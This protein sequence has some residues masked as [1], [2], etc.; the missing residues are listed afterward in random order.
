MPH[1]VAEGHLALQ[2][3]YE[4]SVGLPGALEM[5]DTFD[6]TGK[7]YT[8]GTYAG[9]GTFADGFE[10]KPGKRIP[11]AGLYA[12]AGVGLARAEWRFFDAEAKGPNA[13]A[14]VGA[15]AASLSARAFARAEVAS[16]SATAGPVKA[17]VG[18]AVD[19]GVGVVCNVSAGLP[20]LLGMIDAFDQPGNVFAVGPYAS[21]GAFAE[22]FEN[23]PGKRLPKA[24]ANPEA[25]VGH[26]QA[27]RSVF[28]AE[29]KG[30]NASAGVNASAADLG[31]RAFAKAELASASATA[32]PVKATAGLA[33]NTGVSVGPT[34]L[35][36]KVLGTGFSIGP[37]P[38]ISLFG[39]GIEFNQQ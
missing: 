17:T 1:P 37:K 35:E 5:I 19:T 18:L 24:G 6:R 16:A 34:G 12:S 21:A 11:K 8:A 10:D 23:K 36:A 13:S 15:S 29:V 38:S 31:A 22:G 30:P 32:G 27:E 4:V 2:G 3:G 33:A 9:A 7:A 14:G 25:G 26:A 20:G 39:S 28:D